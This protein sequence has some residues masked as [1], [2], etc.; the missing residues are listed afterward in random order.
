MIFLTDTNVDSSSII[1]DMGPNIGGEVQRYFRQGVAAASVVISLA[2]CAGEREPQSAQTLPDQV[3]ATQP[4][5]VLTPEPLPTVVRLPQATLPSVEPVPDGPTPPETDDVKPVTVSS[6]A[7]SVR[8]IRSKKYLNAKNKSDL[9]EIMDHQ[10]ALKFRDQP[11][12]FLSDGA[13]AIEIVRETTVDSNLARAL[14]NNVDNLE[15]GKKQTVDD[16]LNKKYNVVNCPPGNL[17]NETKASARDT[18]RAIKKVA[19][20]EVVNFLDAKGEQL[21]QYVK[22]KIDKYVKKIEAQVK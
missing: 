12:H 5:D 21:G 9:E 19:A 8:P 2:A 15:K 10:E 16:L 6:P 20:F 4:T 1:Y 18:F 11:I 14:G 3:V 22:G 13:L 17:K 7:C